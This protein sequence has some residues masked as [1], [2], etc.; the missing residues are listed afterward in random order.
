MRKMLVEIFNS[1]N[2]APTGGQKGDIYR[3]FISVY[4]SRF[5]AKF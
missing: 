5:N 2:L 4:K 1:E 3:V